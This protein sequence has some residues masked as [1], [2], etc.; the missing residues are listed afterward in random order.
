MGLEEIRRLK[1]QAGL[2]KVK[3]KKPIPK[4]SA[5]KIAQ[6]KEQA[7]LNKINGDTKEQWYDDRMKE[8]PPIC[9]NCGMEAPWLLQPE[10][11]KIWRACQ[12]HILPKRP[13]QFPSVAQ[14]PL[15]HLVLFPVWGGYLCGC[16][17]EFDSS[18]YNATTMSVWP[19]AVERFKQFESAI[20][21]KERYRIPEQFLK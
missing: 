12:A 16:H 9:M 8:N 10:Y 4:K 3:S 20:S 18:W 7:Q 21:A 19:Q 2:P 1:L 11:E 14:H 17:D 15:N 13:S 6:E 5:K